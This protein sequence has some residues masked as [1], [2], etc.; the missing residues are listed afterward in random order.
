MKKQSIHL[1]DKVATDI[2]KLKILVVDDQ[3]F[4]TEILRQ[5]LLNV[6]VAK[7]FI[8]KNAQQAVKIIKTTKVDLVITDFK[9]PD[10]NGLELL[11]FIRTSRINT[12]R[13]LPV[14]MITGFSNAAVFNIALQLDITGFI[15]KPASTDIIIKRLDFVLS[16]S[17][18]IQNSDY[19]SKIVVPKIMENRPPKKEVVHPHIEIEVVGKCITLDEVM[20]G[21]ILTSDIKDKNNHLLLDKST[22]LTGTLI[23]KLKQIQEVAGINYIH[24]K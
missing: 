20:P 3:K 5:T 23:E 22:E 2:S 6:G 24:V 19:Y 17:Q 16:H 10:I 7:V 11:K 8:A 12:I 18:K 14:I 4:V 1:N 15:A 21:E 13:N 9:M